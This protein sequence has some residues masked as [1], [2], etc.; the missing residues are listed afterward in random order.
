MHASVK[1]T[2]QSYRAVSADCEK[3]RARGKSKYSISKQ[4]FVAKIALRHRKA[5]ASFDRDPIFEAFDRRPIA[6]EGEEDVVQ[7]F[8]QSYE[9]D[10][11][12]S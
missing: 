12:F 7:R 1:A 11:Q 2:C 9:D 5:F 8:S 4:T 6:R 10:R 3:K